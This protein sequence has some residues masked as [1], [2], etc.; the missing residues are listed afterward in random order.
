MEWMG[1]VINETK[2]PFNKKGYRK[3]QS[4][5]TLFL[6]NNFKVTQSISFQLKPLNRSTDSSSGSNYN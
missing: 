6:T 4:S 3:D 2:I 5:N 1:S